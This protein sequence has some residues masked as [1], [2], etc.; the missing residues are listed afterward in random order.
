MPKPSILFLNRVYPPVRGATGRML[1]DLARSFARKGWDVTVVTSGLRAVQ[2]RDGTVRV[3]R[4]KGPTKP[5]CVFSYSFVLMKML[6]AAMRQPKADIVVSMTDPP[7][8]ALVGDVIKKRKGSKHIHWC[9][10]L[11]PDVFPVLEVNMPGFLFQFL[12]KLSRKAIS[13]A[14]KV[15]VIG[16][17]MARHLGH[18]GIEPKNMTVI[19]NWPEKELRVTKAKQ[20]GHDEVQDQKTEKF[21][22]SH[23]K[24]G[25]YRKAEQQVRTGPKFRVLYAGNIGRAHPI[26]TI[27]G[28]AEI[29]QASNPEIEFLFVGD[30][31]RYDEIVEIRARKHLDNIRLLPYQ[32]ASRLRELMESGDIHLISMKEEAAGMVVPSKLYAALAAQR[33]CIMIGPAHSEAAKVIIDYGAGVVLPQGDADKLAQAI[34]HYRNSGDDWFAAQEGSA[35]AGKVFVPQASVSVWIERAQALIKQ[36][37]F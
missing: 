14:D 1:R 30:G 36:D 16:R 7:M 31:P 10:D 26:E 32:P 12:K 21:V 17:C 34:L 37:S 8:L 11:Y 20:H 19:P 28:A 5:G 25:D 2:E 13:D 18:G 9:Q 33:P 24:E 15:I 29:L 27:L 23:E 35:N 4:V 22:R 6:A 3:I